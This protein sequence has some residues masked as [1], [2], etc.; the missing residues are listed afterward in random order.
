[1]QTRATSV[2]VIGAGPAGLGAAYELSKDNNKRI[3]ITVIDKNSL[4]GGLARTHSHKGFRFDVGPHRYFTKNNEVLSLWKETLGKEFKQIPRLTRMYYKGKFFLYPI[5]FTDIIKKFGT[6][7]LV[8]STLSFAYAKVFLR[9]LEA[10]TFEDWITK[11]FGYKLY[12]I[13]FKSYTE[14]LWGVPCNQISADWASQRIK[15]ANFTEVV[16]NALVKG[17]KPKAKTWVDKFYYPAKGSGYM[18][19]K[20]AKK[21]TGSGAKIKLKSKVI[22]INHKNNK[23][24]SVDYENNGKIYR[25]KAQDFFASMPI[26]HFVQALSPKP[27]KKILDASRKLRFREHISV[28]LMLKA[29]NLFPDNWIYIHDPGYKMVRVANYNNFDKNMAKDKYHSAVAVEY[30]TFQ[31]EKLWK[32]SDDELKDLAVNEMVRANL[33]KSEQVTGGFVVRETESYPTYF[34]NEKKYFELIKQYLSRFNNLYLIGRGGMFRYN[35][36]D[37]A[38]YTGILA[39]RNLIAGKRIFNVWDVN[40]DAEYLESGEAK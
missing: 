2:V 26:T 38:I 31:N 6:V 14:K 9:N 21:I 22:K 24:I 13:F 39:A 8:A 28:N 20:L 17:D 35:N 16:K 11:N 37:H 29:R 18:Y 36:M 23:I 40:V 4:V 30:F 32:L 10:K 25:A 33:I 12:S 34:L 19:E 3:K 15:N 27:P 7:D 5:E 1:M